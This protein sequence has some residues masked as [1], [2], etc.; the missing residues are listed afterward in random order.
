MY[1]LKKKANKNVLTTVIHRGST[2]MAT[3]IVAAE[4]LIG[5][6]IVVV[7]LLY[8]NPHGAVVDLRTRSLHCKD[9]EFVL[10]IRSSWNYVRGRGQIFLA[11]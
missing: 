3:A 10:S 1:N 7:T 2:H 5:T 8:T 6:I 4:L 9:K 11:A